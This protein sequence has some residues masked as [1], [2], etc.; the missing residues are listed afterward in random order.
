MKVGDLVRVKND[1]DGWLGHGIVLDV[2]VLGKQVKVRWFDE[3]EEC[4]IDWATIWTLE[5]ISE[6]RR[7]HIVQAD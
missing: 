6:S 3:W 4:P 1:P 7:S 5:V 2:K